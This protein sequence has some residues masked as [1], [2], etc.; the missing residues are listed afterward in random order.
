MSSRYTEAGQELLAKA[1]RSV[2]GGDLLQASE[3]GWGA[4]AQAVKAV[5]ERRGWR[6]DNHRLLYEI[7]NR[8]A[9]EASDPEIRTLFSVASALHTNFYE[10]W[11][12]EEMVASN[13]EKVAE[14]VARLEALP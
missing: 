12:P 13:V 3:K 11:M 1:K 6:H 8:L 4:A 10:H 7:A 14:L 2:Y 5:A 9:T